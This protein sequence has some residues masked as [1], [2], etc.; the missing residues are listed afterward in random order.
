MKAIAESTGRNVKQIKED[1]KK[2]GDLGKVAMVGKK[3]YRP[4]DPRRR[5]TSRGHCSSPSR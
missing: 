2:E 3:L 4:A 5:A 1:L